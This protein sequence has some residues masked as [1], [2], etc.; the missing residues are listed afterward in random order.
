MRSTSADCCPFP[1]RACGTRCAQPLGVAGWPAEDSW[2]AHEDGTYS[3]KEE[4]AIEFFYHDCAPEDARWAASLLRPQ[5]Q[6]PIDEITP[7]RRWPAVDSTYVLCRDDRVV[8]PD[9][10]RMHVPARLGVRPLE[11]PG[12]HAPFVSRPAVLADTLTATLGEAR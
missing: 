8:N 7:L 12:G 9:W 1:V 11:L 4:P 2:I 5:A 10:S 6:T 3:W